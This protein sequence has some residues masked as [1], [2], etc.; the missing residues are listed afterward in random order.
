MKLEIP[1]TLPTTKHQIKTE[2]IRGYC[3][4]PLRFSCSRR[5]W[6]PHSKGPASRTTGL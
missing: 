2:L 5:Q 4:Q 3:T 6:L 1:T